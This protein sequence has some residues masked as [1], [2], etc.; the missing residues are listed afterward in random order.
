MGSLCNLQCNAAVGE[1][2]VHVSLSALANGLRFTEDLAGTDD[3]ADLGRR[4]L[5]GLARLVPA[6]VLTY[7]ELGPGPGLVAYRICPEDVVFSPEKIA[8]FEAHVQENPLVGHLHSTGDGSPV[9]ISDFLT[10]E[11]FHRLGV[12]TEFYRHVPVEHQIAIG[13]P[14]SDGRVI[15]IALSRARGDFTEDDRDLLAVLRAPL[16][17]AMSRARSR[18]RARQALSGPDGGGAAGLTERELELLELVAAG[19]TNAAIARM[20]QVSP[21][22]VANHLDHIYRKLEVSSR[23]AAVYRAVNEGLVIP[24]KAGPANRPRPGASYR[25]SAPAKQPD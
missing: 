16:V 9:K 24:S 3:P 8:A 15:G 2:A 12:Y 14:P 6:D 20:L 13:L 4:A 18:Y 7:N 25:R 23:A 10:R 5:P 17:R 22:T 11:R 21:R 19:H 1:W